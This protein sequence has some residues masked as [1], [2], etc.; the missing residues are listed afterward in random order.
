MKHRRQLLWLFIVLPA[1]WI[2][3]PDHSSK[4]PGGAGT[5]SSDV[6]STALS[7]GSGTQTGTAAGNTSKNRD[8]SSKATN[9]PPRAEAESSSPDVDYLL[10][11]SSLS[12]EEAA[13]GMRQIVNDTSKPM[14]YRVEAMEHG[15]NL[16]QDAFEDLATRN[17]E[18][19]VEL[20]AVFLSAVMNWNERPADQISTYLSWVNHADEE[21]K[22]QSLE[23]LRFMLEDDAGEMSVDQLKTLAEKRIQELRAE[24]EAQKISDQEAQKGN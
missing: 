17:P 9:K 7:K 8:Q 2:F 13:R 5:Q 3:W 16:S 24:Q 19:P 10:T 6:L 11:D 12:E 4:R 22:T 14:P 23:M 1:L 18:L 15:L 20:A 21:I